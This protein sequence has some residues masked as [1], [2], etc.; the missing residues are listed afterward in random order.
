MIFSGTK[1]QIHPVLLKILLRGTLGSTIIIIL[2]IEWLGEAWEGKWLSS[3][4]L[5]SSRILIRA[6]WS[7]GSVS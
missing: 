5:V 1:Q 6:F 2:E 7:Y 4:L 3:G